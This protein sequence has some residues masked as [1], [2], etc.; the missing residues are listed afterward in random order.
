MSIVDGEELAASFELRAVD[1]GFKLLDAGKKMPVGI[2][3]YIATKKVIY[4]DNSLDKYIF[5]KAKT[6][7][8]Q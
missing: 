1:A 6:S 8:S 7:S 4:N 5:T 2:S 3:I